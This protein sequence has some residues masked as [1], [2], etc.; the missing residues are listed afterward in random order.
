MPFCRY[1]RGVALPVALDDT[2]NLTTAVAKLNRKVFNLGAEEISYSPTIAGLTATTVKAERKNQELQLENKNLE[3][4]LVELAEAVA[5]T[6][7][8]IGINKIYA[9]KTTAKEIEIGDIPSA[10]RIEVQSIIEPVEE[11][12]SEIIK[13]PI[14]KKV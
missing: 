4:A 13:E 5:P 12:V 9:N 10:R 7:S 3:N 11:N 1:L 8:L 6:K 14:K 2:D